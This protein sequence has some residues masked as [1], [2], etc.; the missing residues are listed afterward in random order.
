MKKFLCALAIMSVL[1]L[2]LSGCIGPVLN[3][4]EEIA[5]T[6]INSIEE[7]DLDSLM[8]IYDDPVNYNGTLT[9]LANMR[10]MYAMAFTMLD[11]HSVTVVSKSTD[12]F[13][14]TINLVFD[15]DS[16]SGDSRTTRRFTVYMKA[17]IVGTKWKVCIEEESSVE[18]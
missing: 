17:H 2:A 6:Y 16:T 14:G 13:E 7:E 3:P 1:V 4:M 15:M 10:S 8:T 9:A 5:S 12:L 11:I 18:L